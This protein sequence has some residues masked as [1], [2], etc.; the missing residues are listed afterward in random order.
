MKIVT[1]SLAAL[2]GVASFATAS[3][4]VEPV[5]GSIT[6]SN[7]EAVRFTKAPAGSSLNHEFYADG[8]KYNESYI[9]NNDGSI[10]LTG[11]TIS[12][13]S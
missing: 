12:N 2:V 5:P 10:R 13:D 9:I 11:R 4:A 3:L 1:I 8:V 7:P 6:Y